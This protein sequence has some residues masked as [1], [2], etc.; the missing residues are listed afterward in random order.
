MDKGDKFGK[1]TL[2]SKVPHGRASWNVVCECGK[3]LVRREDHLKSGRTRSCKSCSAKD[4]ARKFGMPNN[5]MYVG[6]LGRTYYSTIK[7]SAKRRGLHFDMSQ[8][9]LWELFLKQGGKCG[10]TGIDISL[11]TKIKDCG[12]DYS[13]FTAS[14][15]R[16]DSSKG[17]LL[18]NVHWVHRD[19]NRLKN[20][21]SLE[22]FIEMCNMVSD[23]AN[24]QPSLGRDSLEGSTTNRRD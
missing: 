13:S 17:Y 4:T 24:Q 18:N 10:L 3:E 16:I 21:Y 2:V 9:S 14:L 6:D 11:S 5:S 20:N 8:E 22:R 12:P 23:Y 7:N 19:F 1:L 15:D